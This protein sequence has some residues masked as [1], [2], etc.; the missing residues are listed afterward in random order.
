MELRY[1]IKKL[2]TSNVD[3]IDWVEAGAMPSI[4]TKIHQAT[5]TPSPKSLILSPTPPALS[6]TL[7]PTPPALSPAP[8]PT[9]P[10]PYPT[11]SPQLFPAQSPTS[12]ALP[13]SPA[14]SPTPSPTTPPTSPTL[15]RHHL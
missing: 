11:T 5:L 7:S 13:T 2:L 6:L 1:S 10:A 9:S 8:S 14:L 3:L 4:L 15:S 12:L